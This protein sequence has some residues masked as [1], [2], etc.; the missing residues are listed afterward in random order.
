MKEQVILC[1]SGG[2]DSCRALHELRRDSRYEVAALLSTV[3]DTYDRVS[4][5]GVRRTLLERQ[6]E[7]LGLPLEIVLI[8]PTCINPIY[9][10]RMEAALLRWKTQG[11]RRVAFGDIFLED[12]RAYRERNLARVSMEAIF[13]I[14]RRPT[15]EL[16]REFLTLGFR[17][18]TVCVDPRILDA[19]FVGCEI[20]EDFLLRLP[21]AADPC[22][23]NGEFHSFVY[24]GPGFTT[25][26][27]F[28][29]G[30]I[31]LREGFYFCDLLPARPE[32]GEQP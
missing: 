20:T 6:A 8:P 2:K 7:S 17:G 25:P 5:H 15:R 26:V 22:G 18:V 14:W 13:P 21:A 1:W 9:E 27:A 3:T 31:V 16:A 11:V 4:M 28:T 12:L 29:R 10:A 30:E 24:D 19:S 23:E 32:K